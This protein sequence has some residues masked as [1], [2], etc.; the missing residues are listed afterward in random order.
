MTAKI[1]VKMDNAAFGETPASELA[2]ILRDLAHEIENNGEE[3]CPLFDY[4][5]NKVGE[6]AIS[7]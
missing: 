2:R 1:T 6:F 5:G 3:G 7:E 4:N